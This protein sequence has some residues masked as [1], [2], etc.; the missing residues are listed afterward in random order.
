MARDRNNNYLGII[1]ESWEYE[2]IMERMNHRPL[3]FADKF[4][5]VMMGFIIL[6][7]FITY[8]IIH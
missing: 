5:L 6:A 2:Y 4:L 7:S 8:I 3:D 1:P